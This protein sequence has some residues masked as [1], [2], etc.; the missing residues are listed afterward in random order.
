MTSPSYDR[1][2]AGYYNPGVYSLSNPGGLSGVGA[3]R[4]NWSKMLTDF[5][6]VAAEAV[7]G[8]GQATAAAASAFTAP[9]TKATSVTE[10]ELPTALP[11]TL[12]ITLVEDDR[13]FVQGQTAVVSVT[14]SALNQASGPILSFDPLTKLLTFNAQIVTGEGTFDDWQVALTAPADATLTGRVAAL[15]AG[16]L[17]QRSAALFYAKEFI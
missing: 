6:A 13:L 14:G 8:A 3:V 17:I 10:F 16:N 1:L 11:A 12:A 9:G 7:A 15:E 4:L 5:A 2:F